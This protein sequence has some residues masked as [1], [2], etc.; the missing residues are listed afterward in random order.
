MLKTALALSF[1][2]FLGPLSVDDCTL[3]TSES[4]RTRL[5]KPHKQ[6]EK[7]LISRAKRLWK[8]ADRKVRLELLG[9]VAG[10]SR[11]HENAPSEKVAAFLADRLSD[12]DPKV[13]EEAARLLLEGQHPDVVIESLV[14]AL[15]DADRKLTE[16]CKLVQKD[17]A[18]DWMLFLPAQ[19][20]QHLLSLGYL[21]DPR[22]E[23]ALVDFMERRATQTPGPLYVAAAH[24]ALQLGSRG[25]V[26]AVAELIVRLDAAVRKGRTGPHAGGGGRAFSVLQAAQANFVGALEEDVV[27]ILQAFLEGAKERG[28]TELPDGPEDIEA[29]MDEHAELW[30]AALEPL[31]VPVHTQVSLDIRGSEQPLHER[32]GRG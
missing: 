5:C 19:A 9:D 11:A 15:S 8:K 32:L 4:N 1:L 30:P 20:K 17:E 10:L 2:P 12:G 23:K 6:D 27:W 18:E 22:S 3:C 21:P 31:T 24:G 29:W 26:E 28:A 7:E 14:D 25:A 16:G 13:A